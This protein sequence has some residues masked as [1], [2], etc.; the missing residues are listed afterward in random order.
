MSFFDALF[1][2]VLGGLTFLPLC[3]ISLVAYIWYTAEP[4]DAILDAKEAEAKA[5][6]RE[7]AEEPGLLWGVNGP[8]VGANGSSSTGVNALDLAGG[9][10]GEFGGASDGKGVK[11]SAEVEVP[12]SARRLSPEGTTTSQQSQQQSSKSHRAG[13]V[14]VRRHFDATPPVQ[15]AASTST[16]SLPGTA[17]VPDSSS[18]SRLI[19]PTGSGADREAASSPNEKDDDAVSVMSNG[20]GSSQKRGV[21]S[22]MYRGILDYR[23]QRAEAKRQR[24]AF[25]SSKSPDPDLGD[26]FGAGGGGGGGG[27]ATP[28]NGSSASLHPIST[29]ASAAQ[30][31]IYVAAGRDHYYCMLK[32]PILYIYS[33]DDIKNPNTE[34]YA[35]IDM[36]GKRVSIYVS[37]IGD[38]QGEPEDEVGGGGRGGTLDDEDSSDEEE[39]ADGSLPSSAPQKSAGALLNASVGGP[40][41]SG[42]GAGKKA[43]AQS[44]WHKLQRATIKDGELFVKRNAVRIVSF[45]S[46]AAGSTP[47]SQWFVFAKSATQLEDWY[48]SL[49]HAS[50]LPKKDSEASSKSGGI[51]TKDPLGAAFSNLDMVSLLASLDSIPDPIPLRWLNAVFGRIFFTVYRTQWLENYITSKMM[52]KIRRVK[53]PTFLSNLR[54]REVDVG[55]SPPAFSRPMLK[56]L[57]GDG[58]ASMEVSIHYTGQMR[59]TI[60]TDLTISLGSRFKP[61]TV[62]L[63]LAVVIRSLEGNILL[64]IKPPPSNRLWFGFTAVPK[65]TI[66]IEPVVSERKVQWGMVT[67]LI[68]GRIKELLTESLVVPNMDDVPF[69][70]TR[71]MDQRGGVWA[72]AAKQEPDLNA[73]AP[74]PTTG[75][76]TEQP[77]AAPSAKVPPV[78]SAPITPIGT[79]LGA[80]TP[81]QE[82]GANPIGDSSA[83][84]VPTGPA[85]SSVR[86]RRGPPSREHLS[87]GESASLDQ[88]SSDNLLSMTSPAN[89]SAAIAGLRN[90]LS[91]DMAA[92]RSASTQSQTGDAKSSTTRSQSASGSQS[93][94]RSWLPL[95]AKQPQLSSMALGHASFVRDNQDPGSQSGTD[96]QSYASDTDGNVTGSE[97]GAAPS[98]RSQSSQSDIS[99][100]ESGR[101]GTSIP[102]ETDD[103][104]REGD[105]EDTDA[106]SNFVAELGPGRTNPLPSISRL[107]FDDEIDRTS[108]PVSGLRPAS[109]APRAQEGTTQ[110]SETGQ[111]LPLQD[112]V[113]DDELRTP[114]LQQREKFAAEPPTPT[115]KRHA[116]AASSVDSALTVPSRSSTRTS[117]SEHSSQPSVRPTTEFKDYSQALPLEKTSSQRSTSA[118]SSTSD[119]SPSTPTR[120]EAPPARPHIFEGGRPI[121]NPNP[122]PENAAINTLNQSTSALWNKAKASLADKDARQAAAKDAKDALKRGWAN[123]NQKRAES[124]AIANQSAPGMVPQSDG[125]G[126]RRNQSPGAFKDYSAGGRS[127]SGS[128]D[129]DSESSSSR[130]F[131]SSPPDPAALGLGIESSRSASGGGGGAGQG[132]S[133]DSASSSIR[134]GSGKAESFSS[135]TGRP[136]YRDYLAT[137]YRDGGRVG[138]E[139]SS[140]RSTSTPSKLASDA[141]LD[142][143]AS[144]A[145]V[146]WDA[147]VPTLAPPAP[148]ARAERDDLDGGKAVKTSD[149]PS[150]LGLGSSPHTVN[151]VAAPTI[152][153]IPS[154][155]SGNGTGATAGSKSGVDELSFVPAPAHPTTSLAAGSILDE[156][157]TLASLSPPL[158]AAA[159]SPSPSIAAVSSAPFFTAASADSDGLR[160]RTESVT[161]LTDVRKHSASRSVKDVDAFG[162]GPALPGVTT[163]PTMPSIDRIPSGGSGN[164]GYG[165]TS[166]G[167]PGASG[168]G[169]V[170]T[171]PPRAAMMAIPGIPATQKSEPQSFSAPPPSPPPEEST[172]TAAVQPS[173]T[174]SLNALKKWAPGSGNTL[175]EEMGAISTG[176]SEGENKETGPDLAL[177][178]ASLPEEKS[179][180]ATTATTTTSEPFVPSTGA[181]GVQDDLQPELIKEVAQGVAQ[182]DK[183]QYGEA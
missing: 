171:Q 113:A 25:A 99:A 102:E 156:P 112:T 57:T 170:R 73:P 98:L 164:A 65:M 105:Q 58:E 121:Y 106:E 165:R 79:P 48:H 116:S 21:M 18:S 75:S 47:Y 166:S 159:A 104:G 114:P 183:E 54:V 45:N 35:A 94:R 168:G 172:S 92:N 174:A 128:G 127:S 41:D 139:S 136:A 62:S 43:R 181:A 8:S 107:E 13:W 32:G 123:W 115:S 33:S 27:S 74:I 37:G 151:R 22:A 162:A 69:F 131:A 59:I 80:G 179:T 137:K 28:S 148:I 60:S 158:T 46:D 134:S 40:S 177:V 84:E 135:E 49:I 29:G 67:R 152:R 95:G 149:V 76:K 154:S 53:T 15:A 157:L 163:T 16:T 88:G 138:S 10:A 70:D 23:T 180:P 178:G 12:P 117:A 6:G 38:A 119:D 56:T 68:E 146:A 82:I 1:Y 169:G 72:S 34:C 81:S 147:P 3:V 133:R 100:D 97:A 71:K 143:T 145:A 77:T 120:R 182:L 50:W 83:V 132:Q 11:S 167:T 111:E 153:R 109:Q 126:S 87:A 124:R 61:Y 4:V 122:R 129:Q 173:L 140:M 150:S 5:R 176:P 85:A 17:A 63:L 66:G 14:T 20:S 155:S 89:S 26:S 44:N 118:G 91:R 130:W 101:S 51:G 19:V 55:R 110:R 39:D 141:T 31:Q 9:G 36:R 93:R 103:E 86:S 7:L 108:T 161:A 96:G 64:M 90:T 78:K 144:P 42:N 175:T 52:K 142:E 160:G 125:D 30:Q 2:Y 24:Q